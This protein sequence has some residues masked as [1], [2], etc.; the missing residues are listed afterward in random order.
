MFKLE[1]WNFILSIG[2]PQIKHFQ[3]STVLM[4]LTLTF[5]LKRAILNKNIKSSSG[6]WAG[7]FKELY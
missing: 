4:T 2:T 1:D 3:M 7:L 5:V 6:Y